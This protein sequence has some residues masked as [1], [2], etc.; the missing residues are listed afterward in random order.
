MLHHNANYNPRDEHL[1]RTENHKA[2][3]TQRCDSDCG[4]M[5]QNRLSL[6]Q[7]SLPSSLRI[8]RPIQNLLSVGKTENTEPRVAPACA[9]PTPASLPRKHLP[10]SRLS[11]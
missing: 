8:P 6:E 5:N 3:E 2:P 10:V 1:D 4:A 9:P 11:T 7:M